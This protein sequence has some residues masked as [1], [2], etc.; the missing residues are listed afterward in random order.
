MLLVFTYLHAESMTSIK[1]I[2][3]IDK[4]S[5]HTIKDISKNKELFHKL[6]TNNASFGFKNATVWIYLTIKNNTEK[7]LS[8]V[9]YFP[10]PLHDYIHVFKYKNSKLDAD[11]ITGD[12]TN[13]DTREIIDNKFIIPY[14]LSPKETKIIILKINSQSSLNLK[15]KFLSTEQYYVHERNSQLILGAYYGAI[16]IMLLYNLILFFV[17][18]AKVYLDYVLFHFF[19]LFLQL[20]LNGLAFEFLYPSFPTLN[21]YFIPLSFTLSNFFAIKFSISFLSLNDL[22]PRI[23]S[24]LKILSI[25]SLLLVV[26]T[27][28]IPYIYIIKL[29]TLLSMLTAISLFIIGIITLKTYNNATSKFFVTAWSFLLIG[30]LAE[31]SLNIGLLE[32][33]FFTLYGA[34]IG[35]FSELTLLSIALAYRYNSIYKQ[36]LIKEGSLQILN[37]EL[38]TKVE[39]RTKILDKKNSL[40]NT[41]VKNKNFLLRE[42]YHRVKNNLQVISGLLSLQAKRITDKE[43]KLVFD[44]SIQRI[45][46]IALIH[47]KLY[48]SDNLEIISMQ[49]YTQSLVSDLEKSFQHDNLSFQVN[50]DNINLNLEI[51]VPLGLIINE[52]VTNALKYAFTESMKNPTIS[53]IMQIFD[54]DTFVLEISDNGKGVNMEKLQ[55]GFGS[56]LLEFLAVYQ[57]KGNAKSYNHNGLHTKIF[58]SK[59]LLI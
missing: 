45:K 51:A 41:E 23:S 13:F 49:T 44:E 30:V 20:G 1:K 8:K 59:E 9:M 6:D 14:K 35:T 58:L 24:Y 37:N 36:L 7:H 15:I 52:L 3:F 38:E 25:L 54:D 43:A 46:S 5:T 55:E 27:F 19:N 40:L 26:L 2:Y 56:K 18:K 47:E 12:M 28:F 33:N 31:M 39:D 34:Q 50:C 17:I 42:L 53:I 10:Y 21:L 4:N 16:I 22:F 29:I 11:Y 48:N 57:L 32:M